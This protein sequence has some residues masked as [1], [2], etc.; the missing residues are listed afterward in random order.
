MDHT[1]MITPGEFA[2]AGQSERNRRRH[3]LSTAVRIRRGSQVVPWLEQE[4]RE[5]VPYWH[6]PHSRHP[7]LWDLHGSGTAYRTWSILN[8]WR[9]AK[10]DSALLEM[11]D[12]RRFASSRLFFSLYFSGSKAILVAANHGMS[13]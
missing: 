6:S 13:R 4:R 9:E 2:L 12:K 3:R 1:E 5:R 10:L 7:S 8:G 11:E